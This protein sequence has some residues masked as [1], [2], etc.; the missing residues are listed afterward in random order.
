M[1]VFS[2][3][4]SS[5]SFNM[6]QPSAA[7]LQ[8]TAGIAVWALEAM[9]SMAA[10]RTWEPAITGILLGR[11]LSETLNRKSWLSHVIPNR[12]GVSGEHF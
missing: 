4:C 7:T 8:T 3:R 5:L 9:V 6:F 11:V 2:K 10:R 1:R 12:I